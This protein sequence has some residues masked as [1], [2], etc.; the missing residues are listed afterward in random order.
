MGRS[1]LLIA[2]VV[3]VSAALL[4]PQGSARRVHV[5]RHSKTWSSP[6]PLTEE[7]TRIFIGREMVETEMDYKDPVANTN[8]RSSGAI[9]NSPTPPPTQ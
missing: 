8:P 1:L 9:F 3:A 6:L 4:F 2:L 5:M 7:K